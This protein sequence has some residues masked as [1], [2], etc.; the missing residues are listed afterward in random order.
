ML[1]VDSTEAS[2][3]DIAGSTVCVEDTADDVIAS[4]P[5]QQIAD[6]LKRRVVAG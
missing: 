3:A 4:V 1:Y 6:P 2:A 5:V